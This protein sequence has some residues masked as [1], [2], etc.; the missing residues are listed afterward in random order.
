MSKIP[1]KFRVIVLEHPILR[2]ASDP[3]V[4][5]RSLKAYDEDTLEVT[6]MTGATVIFTLAHPLG[7]YNGS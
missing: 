3:E 7:E 2:G 1:E 6:F 5:I 4:L